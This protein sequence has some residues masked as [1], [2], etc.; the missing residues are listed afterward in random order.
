[1]LLFLEIIGIL[2]P[3]TVGLIVTLRSKKKDELGDCSIGPGDGT[4]CWGEYN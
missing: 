2:L 4:G 1:M 3:V